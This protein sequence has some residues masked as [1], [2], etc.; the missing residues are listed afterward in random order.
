MDANGYRTVCFPRQGAFSGAG[1]VPLWLGRSTVQ[2]GPFSSDTGLQPMSSAGAAHLLGQEAVGQRE[3][4][5]S[6][7]GSLHGPLVLS[8]FTA[9]S[10]DVEHS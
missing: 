8:V 7:H 9:L 4:V 2:P 3:E 6:T 1:S 5:W 10:Q